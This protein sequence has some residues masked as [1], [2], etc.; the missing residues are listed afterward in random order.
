VHFQLP[1][2]TPNMFRQKSDGAGSEVVYY[3][4]PSQRFL[5]EIHGLT[6]P[7]PASL[8]FLEW[9]KQSTTSAAMRS[10]FKCMAFVHD[11]EK[12]N[13]GWLKPYNAKPVLITESGSIRTGTIHRNSFRYVEMSCN[14][15]QW[16]FM[17]KKSFVGLLP[18]FRDLKINVGFTIEALAEQEMPEC[19]L[20]A[21]GMNYID[22]SKLITIPREL[23]VPQSFS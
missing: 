18:R 2:E 3:L 23:Q 16:A 10:R 5:N 13:L 20:G 11:L 22:Q 6:T 21:A 19:I 15:H 14:V 9:C 17:A 12:L 4:R 8:L 1:F 7:T